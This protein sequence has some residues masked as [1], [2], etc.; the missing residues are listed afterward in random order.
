MADVSEP[1]TRP[2][3]RGRGALVLILLAALM[4]VAAGLLTPALHITNFGFLGE[5]VTILS[6]IEAFYDDG[7]VLLATLI[8]LVSVLFPFAKI[9]LALMLTLGFNPARRRSHWLAGALAE[10]ARWSMTDVFILAV[11]VMVI[12]AR[13]I[14]AADLRPGAWLFASGVILSST[15]VTILRV[16]LRRSVPPN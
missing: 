9:T 13:L 14:S 10:L 16:R 6:G 2:A 8:L 3:L 7:Q 1:L 4:L 11:A 5:D 12:D 15:A